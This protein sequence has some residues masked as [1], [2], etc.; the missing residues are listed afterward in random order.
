MA[1]IL[2]L[3]NSWLS[4]KLPLT[5]WVSMPAVLGLLLWEIDM[6]SLAVAVTIAST[7]FA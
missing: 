5:E 4:W 1:I 6:T 7:H 3:V 2:Y